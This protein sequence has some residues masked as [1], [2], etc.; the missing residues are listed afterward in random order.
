[1]RFIRTPTLGRHRLDV[2]HP[3]P[4]LLL[5]VRVPRTLDRTVYSIHNSHYN[6]F[7]NM[8]WPLPNSPPGPRRIVCRT[9]TATLTIRNRASIS[10][11]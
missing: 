10:Y 8:R 6:H 1:M 9:V 3:L 4:P 7:Y 2:A 11:G 5:D